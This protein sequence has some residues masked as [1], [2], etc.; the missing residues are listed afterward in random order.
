MLKLV[1]RFKEEMMERLG[2]FFVPDEYWR[3]RYLVNS[4][5]KGGA[6]QCGCVRPEDFFGKVRK[7][8][9]ICGGKRWKRK[10]F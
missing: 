7:Q 2:M 10:I 3:M 9:P 8:Q 4:A 6:R 5:E 1:S